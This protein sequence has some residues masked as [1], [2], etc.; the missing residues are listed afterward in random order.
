MSII[1]H[2]EHQQKISQTFTVT[3][4]NLACRSGEEKVSA[5]PTNVEQCCHHWSSND[6]ARA[7]HEATPNALFAGSGNKQDSVRTDTQLSILLK[8][9]I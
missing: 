8:L 7:I 6:E 5:L 3:H 2:S 9:N 4:W 1:I